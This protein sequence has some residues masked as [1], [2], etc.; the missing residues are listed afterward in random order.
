M[1]V[2]NTI[3][4]H[5]FLTSVDIL[6][7]IQCCHMTIMMKYETFMMINSIINLVSF[8]FSLIILK[9]HTVWIRISVVV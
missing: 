1:H 9:C 3:S 8:I 7:I 5:L 2:C 6:F 4:F